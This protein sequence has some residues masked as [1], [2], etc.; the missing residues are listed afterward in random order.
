MYRKTLLAIVCI[1][2]A[3]AAFSQTWPAVTVPD[4]TDITKVTLPMNT[5]GAVW[6]LQRNFNRSR[7]SIDF[8][9]GPAVSWAK[10]TSTSMGNTQTEYIGVLTLLSQFDVG[11]WLNKRK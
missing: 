7:V 8:N 10:T 5:L 1:P 2:I 4:V 6:G 11:F 3:S 9:I